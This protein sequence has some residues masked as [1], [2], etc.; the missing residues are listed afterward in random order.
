MR[1][2]VT[3]LMILVGFGLM[4]LSYTAL[5]T[6]QC[7]TSVACSNPRVAFAAGIFVVGIVVAF[8]SAIFYSVYKGPR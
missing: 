7:N 8:S 3:T 6:P 1:K 5:G 2:I 4:V